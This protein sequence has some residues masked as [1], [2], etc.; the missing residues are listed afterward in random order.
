[1]KISK[2]IIA[3]TV[4]KIRAKI[5]PEFLEDAGVKAYYLD[6]M[7]ASF[8]IGERETFFG[9]TITVIGRDFHIMQDLSILVQ[10]EDET[11]QEDAVFIVEDP[12]IVEF[13]NGYLVLRGD[14]L[15]RFGA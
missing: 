15:E 4:S 5:E 14:L 8:T 10:D 11:T 1:M 13:L 7:T 6:D 9:L 3:K 2:E 12:S